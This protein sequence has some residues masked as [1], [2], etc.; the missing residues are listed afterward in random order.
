MYP[1]QHTTPAGTAD[2]GSFRPASTA[3]ECLA[4]GAKSSPTSAAD[5]WRRTLALLALAVLGPGIT[6]QEPPAD[7]PAETFQVVIHADNPTTELPAAKVAKMFLKKLKRWDHGVRVRPIDLGFKS[8]VRKAFTRSVHGKSVTA[9][10]SYWQRMIFGRG[11]VPPEEMADD[12]DVLEF[13]RANPGAI[14]YVAAETALG[15][16]V[17]KLEVTE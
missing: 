3:S 12:D 14:G 2:G 15:D 5:F 13:V 6:A 4:S 7:K 11:E 16:G 1:S 10:K 9:I 8:P 17:K